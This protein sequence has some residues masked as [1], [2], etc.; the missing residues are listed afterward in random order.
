M[1]EFFE[2]GYRYFPVDPLDSGEYGTDFH[3][4][5]NDEY[6]IPWDN[7]TGNFL[8]PLYYWIEYISQYNDFFKENEK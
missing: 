7:S 3:T 6:I 4:Y 2:K 5:L 1:S 8:K